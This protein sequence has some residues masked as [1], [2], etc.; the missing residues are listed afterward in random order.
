MQHGESTQTRI[1]K[2]DG[3]ST[4]TSLGICEDSIYNGYWLLVAANTRPA[5]RRLIY[6]RGGVLDRF[7]GPG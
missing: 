4:M 7:Y 1:F 5:V 2:I 3:C 6:T